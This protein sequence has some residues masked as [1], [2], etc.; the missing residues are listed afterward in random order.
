MFVRINKK[1]AIKEVFEHFYEKW[2]THLLI[3]D[4]D[5]D[6]IFCI[7]NVQS[8]DHDNFDAI[9]VEVSKA[10]MYSLLYFNFSQHSFWSSGIPWYHRGLQF[11][12]DFL[13]EYRW[14]NF[15]INR[16]ANYTF[17]INERMIIYE[18]HS[19][20]ISSNDMCI[21][22]CFHVLAMRGQS[23]LDY[24][25]S[26]GSY[27]FTGATKAASKWYVHNRKLQGVIEC[28]MYM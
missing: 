11:S 28:I 10:I 22:L 9:I 13:I 6:R 4:D 19:V 23:Q 27:S 20:L 1:C 12:W 24:I 3:V 14:I 5:D 16:M 25:W 15:Y 7:D 8:K 2:R 26:N 18:R 17:C 21:K